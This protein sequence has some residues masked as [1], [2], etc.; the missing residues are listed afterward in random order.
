[1]NRNILASL[2]ISI[3]GCTQQ[4]VEIK[5]PPRPVPDEKTG[6]YQGVGAAVNGWE[7][8]T[9]FQGFYPKRQLRYGYEGWVLISYTIE[10]DG[11][12]AEIE[13][14]DASPKESEFSF[15]YVAKKTISSLRYQRIEGAGPAAQTK[16]IVQLLD[17]SIQQGSE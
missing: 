17:Y 12:T 16:E 2:I 4:P 3:A 7:L 8:K 11:S 15:E 9:P 14:I 1:M 10:V 6:S 5:P 13:V